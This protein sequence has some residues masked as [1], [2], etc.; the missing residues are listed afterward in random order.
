MKIKM[1]KSQNSLTEESTAEANESIK[2]LYKSITE[3]SHSLDDQRGRSLTCKDLFTVNIEIQRLKLKNYCE[4]MIFSDPSCYGRKAEEILWRKIYHDVYSTAKILKKNN[5]WNKIEVALLENHFQTGIG[6]YYHILFK[7]QTEIHFEI[8]GLF[9]FFKISN[10]ESDANAVKNNQIT[11]MKKNDK[12]IREEFGMKIIIYRC[13]ICLGD[14]TRYIYELNKLDLYYVTAWRYYKQ[15]LLYKPDNG[16]PHNQIGRLALTKNN[17]L[18]AVYH[19]IRCVFS[20]E[21]F[22]GGERNLLLSLQQKSENINNYFLETF[23][24]IVDIW[25]N[26]KDNE[27][28]LNEMYSK[29]ITCFQELCS[30]NIKNKQELLCDNVKSPQANDASSPSYKDISQILTNENIFKLIVIITA[31]LKKLHK[32]DSKHIS[33]AELFFFT[34]TEQLFTQCVNHYSKTLPELVDPFV[35]HTK[36]NRRRRRRGFMKHSSPDSQEWSE[37]DEAESVISPDD[38]SDEDESEEEMLIFDIKSPNNDKNKNESDGSNDSGTSSFDSENK[39][40]KIQVTNLPYA[41]TIH[42]LLYW[43]KHQ[44]HLI[45]LEPSLE[46]L[47]S[48]VKMLNYMSQSNIEN[49]FPDFDVNQFLLP[50]EQHLI[51]MTT[52]WESKMVLSDMTKK[53]YLKNQDA[54]RIMKILWYAKEIALNNVLFTYNSE[55]KWFSL[56]NTLQQIEEKSKLDNKR[57]KQHVMGQLWLRAEVDNLEVQMKYTSRKKNLPTCIVLDTDALI[58]YSLIV[59]K[60]VNSA[61]FIVV[62]PAI[63][64]SALDEQKKLSKEVRLTIRWLEFQLQQGNCSLKSQGLHESKPIKVEETIKISKEM[65]NFKHI[66]EC[67]NYFTDECGESNGIVTLITGSDDLLNSLDMMQMAKSIKINIEHI[68]KLQMQLKM[69]KNKG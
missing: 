68:K 33:K 67:C 50:E 24:I 54:I 18:D 7:F 28:E 17:H 1:K 44:I 58:N 35:D 56:N 34:L 2:K 29:I 10:D 52:L 19:Y 36:L 9:D 46:L 20:V 14:L 27:K 66:L 49:D 21:P 48:I 3:V 22:E 5:V 4:R 39:K 59:K 45:N 57:D 32:I 38:D 16:L 61:M 40:N 11:L 64:I 43:I 6:C 69:A 42:I 31:C 60:L 30:N 53:C 23:F 63:V 13:L 37:G 12:S 41:E 26:G 15:A 62:I 25:Y 65:C 8:P 47:T 55:K 51:G